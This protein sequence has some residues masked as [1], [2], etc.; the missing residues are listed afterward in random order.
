MTTLAFIIKG[1]IELPQGASLTEE[2]GDVFQLSDGTLLGLDVNVE[3]Q[4]SVDEKNVVYSLSFQVYMEDPEAD[5]KSQ[6]SLPT[7]PQIEPEPVVHPLGLPTPDLFAEALGRVTKGNDSFLYDITL[8]LGEDPNFIRNEGDP[9]SFYNQEQL[10]YIKD[11]YVQ[12]VAGINNLLSLSFTIKSL[13]FMGTK[14]NSGVQLRYVTPQGRL[15]TLEYIHA[16]SYENTIPDDFLHDL[17][18]IPHRV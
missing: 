5:H 9:E 14:V 15:H 11:R 1:S 16:E 12:V 7:L 8:R 13:V 10:T 18:H 3:P 17:K 6:E 2:R 4:A